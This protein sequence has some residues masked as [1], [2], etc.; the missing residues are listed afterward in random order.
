[1]SFL[2]ST[3]LADYDMVTAAKES[4]KANSL[5]GMAANFG[6]AVVSSIASSEVGLGETL[7]K[8][9]LNQRDVYL[10]TIE[11]LSATQA[12][13]IKKINEMEKQ[14]KD[15]STLKSYYNDNVK[16]LAELHKGMAEESALP[17]TAEAAG[18][19][20]GTALD[21]L[22]AGTY[23]KATTGMKTGELAAK[24]STLPTAVQAVR[25]L[26]EAPA[27]LVTRKG[28]TRVAV[29]GATGYGYDVTQ[30]LQGARG[31][32]RTGVNA[33]IPGAGTLIGAGMPL[34]TGGIESVKTG[35][36]TGKKL[37]IGAQALKEKAKTTLFGRPTKS[38]NEVISQA[39]EALKPAEMRAQAEANTAI[40]SLKEK[41]AGISSDIK[42]RIAGKSEKLKEYFDVAHARN[43]FDTLP[44]PL[45]HGARS[46]DQA[47]SKMEA[48]L[49]DTGSKIGSFRK[50]VGSYEANIDQV[51]KI[52]NSF[53]D[54]LS[55][56]NLEIQNGVIKQKAGTVARVGSKNDINVLNELYGEMRTVKENPN[57]EK[58]IDLRNVFDRK[59]N[60]E[61]Q[62]RD[63]S[64]AV[65]PVSRRVRKQIADVGAEIVGKSEA[66][67]LKKYSDFMDGYNELRSF[68]DR[69]AGAEFL[70]KQVLSERGR[71][72]REVM[73]VIKEMTG[74]DL[75]DDATMASIATDLIGNSRQKG[76]FRQEIT[77]AGLDAEA[78]LRGKAGAIELMFNFLK[79]NAV[80][81]ENTF[82]KA[83]GQKPVNYT[84]PMPKSTPKGGE[85]VLRYSE[86]VA[87]EAKTAGSAVSRYTEQATRPT[88]PK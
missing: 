4:E 36:E 12:D 51:A 24:A 55:K 61:K 45:E 62:A 68:T 43:N 20:G 50:K 67:N 83:A 77:K 57:L 25:N 18:Q 31:E 26:A 33:L 13:T 56:L 16:A 48:L 10:K 2:E 66:A 65:D 6:K 41:W 37:V 74:I 14:G 81:Q 22:T 54:E 7:R 58:M 80:N 1:M 82:L 44:T 32:D 53:I 5:S 46:V 27:G 64:G 3:L 85:S 60:F 28:A 70:L 72:P 35:V 49:A 17:S 59:I 69:K 21:L 78:L 30:G 42:N 19:I 88:K 52:E 39:D 29:G 47:T 8:T 71:T 9:F 11:N 23:G 86:S 76:L 84:I 34:V 15:A 75:M 40:P 38:I 63:I 87:P 79:K 73:S